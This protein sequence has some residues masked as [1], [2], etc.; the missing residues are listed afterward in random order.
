MTW[1]SGGPSYDNQLAAQGGTCRQRDPEH[2]KRCAATLAALMNDR[3]DVR[4]DATAL[5]LFL[6]VYWSRVETL[7]HS[8][9][10]NED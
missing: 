8:I 5:R 2:A 10:N 4:I 3:L 1:C 9:H 7:A 6:K